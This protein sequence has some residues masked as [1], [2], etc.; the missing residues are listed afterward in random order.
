MGAAPAGGRSHVDLI[1]R[2]SLRLRLFLS[3]IQMVPVDNRV[4][5]QGIG[6]LG[7]PTPEGPQRKHHYMSLA[8]WLIECER[9]IGKSLPPGKLSREQNFICLSGE[10]QHN[11]GWSR[12]VLR[13]SELSY[14]LTG[15]TSVVALRRQ[16]PWLRDI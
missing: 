12:G 11:S 13:P 15:G 14:S 7:L 10:L 2:S 5:A 9:A 1:G 4:E 8:N 3:C 16:S 6:S